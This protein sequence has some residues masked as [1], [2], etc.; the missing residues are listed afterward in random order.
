MEFLFKGCFQ[1]IHYRLD[2]RIF[3]RVVRILEDEREGIGFLTFF[4]VLSFIYIEEEYMLE[5][6]LLYRKSST[7]KISEL[8][9]L[10]HEQREVTFHF[11]I[12]GQVIDDRFVLLVQFE[13][14]IPFQVGIEYLLVDIERFE[15]LA[16][17]D[18][19][20]TGCLSVSGFE[21]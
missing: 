20:E 7:C 2:L 6:F 8:Y 21:N 9:R 4:E 12:F 15:H 1:F 5:Q 17:H 19:D 11:R 16:V 18:T 14:L 13:N 10:I 3:Q